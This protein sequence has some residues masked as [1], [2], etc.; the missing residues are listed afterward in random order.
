MLKSR[1][2][3]GYLS[4]SDLAVLDATTMAP[5]PADGETLGEVMFRANL[6]M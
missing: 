2:G 1:Q 4:L 6:F 5:V 3:V